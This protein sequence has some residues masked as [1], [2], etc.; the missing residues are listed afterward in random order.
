[1]KCALGR[2]DNMQIAPGVDSTDWN[3]LQLD[4]RN[5][6]D[7]TKAIT[8]FKKRIYGRFIDPVDLLIDT[9]NL[10]PPHERRFGFAIMAIDCL[11]VETLGAFLLG[12]EDT[13]NKSEATFSIFLTTRPLFKK[14]FTSV[15]ARRFYYDFRCGILHQA[16]V[17]GTGKVWSVGDLLHEES[18]RLTINR[19]RFHEQLKAEIQNYLA[20]LADPKNTKLRAHFRK[21]MSFICRH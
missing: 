4:D 16:E 9:D 20:E 8:I 15:A 6:A 1:M 2:G 10:K 11:L 21:K 7:W 14:H 19:T 5:S 18:G 12:L 3:K 13:K 17:A